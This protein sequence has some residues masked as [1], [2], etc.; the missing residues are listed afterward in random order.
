MESLDNSTRD[1]FGQSYD[2]VANSAWIYSGLPD[3]PYAA[4][5][6]NLVG[7]HVVEWVGY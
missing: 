3:L 7:V 1:C 6:L 4:P 5:S 2:T